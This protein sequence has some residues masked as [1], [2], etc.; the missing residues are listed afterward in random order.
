MA[1]RWETIEISPLD[2]SYVT[3]ILLTFLRVDVDLTA[4]LPMSTIAHFTL[5]HY[6][7]MV[8]VGAFSDPSVGRL[9]LL[10]GK[11]MD[12]VC[13]KPARFT[14]EQYES[15]V[16]A[17]AFDPP[18]DIRAELI[19]GEIVMMSPIGEPHSLTLIALTEWSY[20]VV[21]KK[22]FMVRVQAP[23]RIPAT[24]S[25]PEPDLVWMRRGLRSQKP[26]E[27]DRIVLVVEV[28]DTS[29][30]YD[31]TVKLAVYSQAGIP[32]YWIVNLV[33][34][35]IEVYRQ[36]SGKSYELSTI[37][38]DQEAVSPLA[39]PLASLQPSQLFEG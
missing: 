2:Q 27:P 39:L 29:L 8:E 33:D 12:K 34:R 10:R 30:E 24:Q 7:H 35:Q 31:R 11:L 3:F 13:A 18:F 21:D 9:E 22:N 25:E 15:M 36:P 17:G 38:R 16:R 14:L 4:D 20:E 37:H 5:A 1:S 28:A 32:E 26:P 19:E 23:I 6:E